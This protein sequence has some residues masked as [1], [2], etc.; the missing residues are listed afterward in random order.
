MADVEA[1]MAGADPEAMLTQDLAV[2]YEILGESYFEE[3]EMLTI[4]KTRLLE[5]EQKIETGKDMIARVAVLRMLRSLQL[6]NLKFFINQYSDYLQ[7][8]SGRVMKS[9]PTFLIE[10]DDVEINEDVYGSF[11][12]SLVHVFRNIMDHGIETDEQRLELGKSE[13]GIVECR[14][15][16]IDDDW[17][18]LRISDDGRG[19]DLDKIK[20]KTLASGL[21]TAQAL[22]K[23]APKELCDLIFVDHLSTKDRADALSGRGLGMSA[24]LEACKNIGGRIEIE[25]E[26]NKGT[27]FV[28]TLP[29][30]D[31]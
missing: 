25:T 9:M 6:K 29:D 28:I 16:R 31:A 8:L 24:V 26:K 19:I 12:K 17:F 18:T 22:E 30:K 2:I 5:I 27:T 10:G 7:Y 11:L 14:I 4:P 13:Q 1:V 20:E 15:T 3:S 23:L 21:M